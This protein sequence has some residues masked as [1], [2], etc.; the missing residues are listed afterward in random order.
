MKK[1]IPLRSLVYVRYLDHVLYRNTPKPI[2]EPA[3]RE[4]IG[5][6]TKDEKEVV[7][8][9]N[10]R[11][12]DELPYSS[13]SGSGLVLLRS[14]I[15]EIRLSPIQKVSGWTLISR[16]TNFRNAESALQTKKRKIQPQ[17]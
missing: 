5:W 16:N 10:D 9:E 8:I 12:L 13:G 15:L 17:S 1:A 11:T 4:T 2:E 6:L 7:C 14:C 3:E